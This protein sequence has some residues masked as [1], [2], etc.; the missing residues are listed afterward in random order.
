MET[1]EPIDYVARIVPRL[2][3][4]EVA[5]LL[6]VLKKF[7]LVRPIDEVPASFNDVLQTQLLLAVSALCTSLVAGQIPGA[8]RVYGPALAPVHASISVIRA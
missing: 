4:A 8:Q 3:P 7:R 6:R 2:I 5:F 1:G